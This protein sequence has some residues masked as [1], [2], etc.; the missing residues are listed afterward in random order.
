MGTSTPMGY[1]MAEATVGWA[2]SRGLAPEA[3][4]RSMTPARAGM[5]VKLPVSR[6][7]A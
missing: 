7:A 3:F 1:A 6:P 5:L 4:T 2:S